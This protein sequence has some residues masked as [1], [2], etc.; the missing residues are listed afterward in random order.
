MNK[1]ILLFLGIV[2]VS[3]VAVAVKMKIKDEGF[4][5]HGSKCLDIKDE[6]VVCTAD[7][8]QCPDGSFVGREGKDCQFKEC[9]VLNADKSNLIKVFNVKSG[10]K[11]SSPLLV[12]GEARGYW[13]F[14]A[15]F[16]VELRDSNNNLIKQFV[17]EA[18]DEWMT[19]EFVPFEFVLNALNFKGNAFLVLK[20][21]NPSDLKEN[22]DQL[23]I[24]VSF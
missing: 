23:K 9:P 18:K 15:S 5:C 20:K 14:E 22:D 3:F 1:K 6:K 7:A 4:F 21:S 2:L 19:E 13:F 16:P 17:A 24:S 8:K 11:I 12:K 10:D